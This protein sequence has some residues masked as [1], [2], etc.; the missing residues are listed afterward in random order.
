[1]GKMYFTKD[2]EE[3]IVK[4]NNTDDPAI[5][6]K[7][8]AERIKYPFEKLAEN[9]INTFKFS[10]F[11]VPQEDVETRLVS[12][13]IEK[14]DMYKPGKGKAFSYFSMIAKNYCILHNKRNYRRYQRQLSIDNEDLNFDATADNYYEQR[15][16]QKEFFDLL[17]KH[18]ED[19]LTSMFTKKRDI[20]IA[21]AV[22]ELFRKRENIETYNKKALYVMIR[23]M[24]GIE[25]TQHITK[26]VKKLKT[27]YKER[28][29]RYY[30]TGSIKNERESHNKFF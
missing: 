12:H 5:R 25:R 4:Y 21:L 3:A 23:E 7:I 17:I 8:Y 22:L 6:S 11:D 13:L 10:Y 18:W 2:T 29:K 16:E 28:A 20:N 19:N 26:V 24:T 14:I 15:E 9:I 30:K 27:D 1:M